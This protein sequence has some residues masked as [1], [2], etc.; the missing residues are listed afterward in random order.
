MLGLLR[1]ERQCWGGDG[2]GMGMMAGDFWDR[3][4]GEAE[5]WASAGFEGMGMGMAWW[6]QEVLEISN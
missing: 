6:G 1:G 2:D 5:E 3:W 4:L